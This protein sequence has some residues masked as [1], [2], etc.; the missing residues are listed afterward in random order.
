MNTITI[1]IILLVLVG[2]TIHT[3]L[4]SFYHVGRLPYPA[5]FSLFV[6][7]FAVSYAFSFTW[8]FGVVAG[9]I[10]SLL[11]FFQLIHSAVLWLF[12]VPRL[13]WL[14][15]AREEPRVSM[16]VYWFHSP[17]AVAVGVLAAISCFKVPYGS[18]SKIFHGDYWTPALACLAVLVIGNIVRTIVLRFIVKS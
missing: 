11:C 3:Y 5:S 8:A 15:H 14:Q 6:S 13:V 9:V 12:Q 16:L 4:D 10:I 2:L 1:S 18:A 17:I 7:L